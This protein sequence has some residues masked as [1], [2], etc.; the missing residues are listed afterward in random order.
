M[1]TLQ[2]S[3]DEGITHICCSAWR[4]TDDVRS[5]KENSCRIV[6]LNGRRLWRRLSQKSY[7]R[8][9]PGNDTHPAAVQDPACLI[10]LILLP[11]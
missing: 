8:M 4:P 6:C 3:F 9:A 7:D 5:T 11:S 1:R 10:Y 2:L